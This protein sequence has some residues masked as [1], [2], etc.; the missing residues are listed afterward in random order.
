MLNTGEQG[1]CVNKN[2]E[3]FRRY[4]VCRLLHSYTVHTI[5]RRAALH[6]K[7]DEWL[8]IEWRL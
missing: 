6:R 3:S 4:A 8:V 1:L 2:V 7:N 5:I